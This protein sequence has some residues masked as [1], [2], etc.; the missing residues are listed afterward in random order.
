MFSDRLQPP[1]NLYI[2]NN[3]DYKAVISWGGSEVPLSGLS[4]KM[5]IKENERSSTI[6]LSL[7]TENEMIKLDNTA[8]TIE[9]VL[10]YSVTSEITWQR[11]SFDLILYSTLTEEVYYAFGG[12]IFVTKGITKL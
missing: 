3:S 12:N 4:A 5:D 1:I 6:L 7:T 8:G 9:I 2:R 10:P 11:G